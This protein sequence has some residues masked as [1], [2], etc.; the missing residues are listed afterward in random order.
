LGQSPPIGVFG[1]W[2]RSPYPA[3]VHWRVDIIFLAMPFREESNHPFICATALWTLQESTA[4]PL[5]SKGT[6]EGGYNIPCH[7]IP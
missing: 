4:L 2:D 5:S 6:L 3:K 7:T 1:L